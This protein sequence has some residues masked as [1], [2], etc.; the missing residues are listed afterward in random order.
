MKCV[1]Y[2][3]IGVDRGDVRVAALWKAANGVPT[4][5]TRVCADLIM[6]NPR[7]LDELAAEMDEYTASQTS[8]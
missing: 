4:E 5:F 1:A 6:N 7:L 3:P 2:I 8:P